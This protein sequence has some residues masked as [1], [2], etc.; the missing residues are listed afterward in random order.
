[1]NGDSLRTD[2]MSGSKKNDEKTDFLLIDKPQ[3]FENV[4]NTSPEYCNDYIDTPE[5]QNI[6][7]PEI[8]P[9]FDFEKDKQNQSR[10]D[11]KFKT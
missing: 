2:E 11:I 9:R 8:T 10:N 6:N 1:L 3:Q 4:L 5:P 7:E